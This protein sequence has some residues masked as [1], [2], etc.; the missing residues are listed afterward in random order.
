MVTTILSDFS[1]VLAT[2]KE[3]NWEIDQKLLDYY[4]ELES[5]QITVAV[6]SA[7]EAVS[8]ADIKN[9]LGAIKIF[10]SKELNLS[11]TDPESYRKITK[12]LGKKPEEVVFVDDRLANIEAAREAG[13]QIVYH[14]STE[15]TIKKLQALV[16][17]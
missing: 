10:S 7:S 12:T 17:K 15:D 8:Q 6:Y 2:L 3:D 13:L 11:K 4:L 9:N 14:T 16:G 1:Y 5:K